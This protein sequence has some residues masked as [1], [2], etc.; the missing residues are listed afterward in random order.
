MCHVNIFLLRTNVPCF[1][2]STAR[3]A[4]LPHTS[5]WV[6]HSSCGSTQVFTCSSLKSPG[7]QHPGYPDR[8]SSS[9]SLTVERSCLSLFSIGVS[10]YN[11]HV[12]HQTTFRLT[13]LNIRPPFPVRIRSLCPRHLS[14]RS[15]QQALRFQYRHPSFNIN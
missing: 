6:H 7:V 2:Y 13:G 5:V 11:I 3:H 1:P 4:A 12:R 15:T 14:F 8:R 9:C 10:P